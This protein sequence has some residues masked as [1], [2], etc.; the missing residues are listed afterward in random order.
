MQTDKTDNLTLIGK[1][2]IVIVI[3]LTPLSV[4][5]RFPHWAMPIGL[6]G[7]LS[8]ILGR[9]ATIYLF[10]YEFRYD[11]SFFFHRKMSD[12]IVS[13]SALGSF[14]VIYI[15]SS[16]VQHIRHADRF[17]LGAILLVAI[18]SA[19]VLIGGSQTMK[20]KFYKRSPD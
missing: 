10:Q 12:V 4:A 17:L 15:L 11:L 13:L 6:C 8:L 3:I 16:W 14:A 19:I 5:L 1:W 18:P 9:E 2:I 7:T 20:A